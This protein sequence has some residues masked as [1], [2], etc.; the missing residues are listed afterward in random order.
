M[1]KIYR[2][3]YSSKNTLQGSPEQ[4][5]TEVQKILSSSRENN[6]VVGITGALLY[7][8]GCFAQVLEGSLEPVETT[9]ERIQRDLRH[10]DVTVL[11]CGYVSDRDFPE[12]S[13]AYASLAP[14][15]SSGPGIFSLP[16]AIENTSTAA[17][18]I[19]SLL[20]TLVLQDD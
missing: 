20:R 7:S 11:E 15:K 6:S 10:A 5:A 3:L 2:I 9:F 18:E 16:S 1:T 17:A 4:Q 8:H 19:N 12:W 14:E 13:M